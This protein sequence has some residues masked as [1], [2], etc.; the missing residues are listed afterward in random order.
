MKL[1][2]RPNDSGQAMLEMAFAATVLLTLMMATIDFGWMFSNKMTLQNAVRQ[3]GRYAIT[4]QCI[5]S[6]GTC[7]ETRYNSVV[8]TLENYSLGLIN[9]NNFASVVTMT[10]TNQGGGCPDNA[11]GPGDI[12]TIQV[13][14]PY[15]FL[16]PFL[17]PLFPNHAYTIKVSSAFTNEPFSPSQS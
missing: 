15:Q 5:E 14:Y 11:G 9:N 16:T 1:G 2:F 8:T 12:V 4:G 10:C 3:A 7:T 6:S 17:A 13:N